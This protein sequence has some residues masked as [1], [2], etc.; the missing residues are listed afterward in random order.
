M[1]QGGSWSKVKE[2]IAPETKKYI[3]KN[4]DL[5]WQYVSERYQIYKR[6]EAGKKPPWTNNPILRDYR[7]TNVFRV[8]DSGSQALIRLVGDTSRLSGADIVWRV[9]QYRWPNHYTLFDDWGWIP[10]GFNQEKWLKRIAKTK[11]KHGQWHTGAHIVLQSNFKQTRAE[12]YMEYLKGLDNDLEQ[13]AASVV[14]SDSMDGAFKNAKKLRGLGGFTAYEVLIDLC[15][16][17]VLPDSFRDQFANSGPGC[18]E[19]LQLIWPQAKSQKELLACM[20]KL[21]DRQKKGFKRNELKKCP[22]L[23]VQDIEFSLCEFSKYIKTAYG[24][25]RR[26]RY[27]YAPV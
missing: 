23:T 4:E 20:V 9:V 26:R 1:P 11:A 3:R 16:L 14:G 7:F 21:R 22:T 24:V 2:K 19:G 6:R 27:R 18:T 15:Y 25:G 17:G 10:R 13:F 8:N 5:F 12:N